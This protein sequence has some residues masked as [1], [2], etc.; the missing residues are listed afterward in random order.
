ML[1]LTMM[2]VMKMLE[3]LEV[4]EVMEMT[5]IWV[6]SFYWQLF[7]EGGLFLACSC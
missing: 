1:T 6:I 2:K 7:L 4:L 5:T 3:V